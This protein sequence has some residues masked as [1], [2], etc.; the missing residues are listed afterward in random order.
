MIEKI[1]KP[2]WKIVKRGDN[3]YAEMLLRCAPDEYMEERKKLQELAKSPGEATKVI[4]EKFSQLGQGEGSAVIDEMRR[5]HKV[6]LEA[7]KE[8]LTQLETLLS[9]VK[10]F[11]NT[12][13]AKSVMNDVWGTI[14]L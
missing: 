12:P 11:E 1:R 5:Q 9:N 6:Q 10:T 13:G 14:D 8:H 2:L 4:L 7:I 3:E